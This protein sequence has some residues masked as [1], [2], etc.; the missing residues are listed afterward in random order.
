[1]Q[2]PRQQQGNNMFQ[3]PFAGMTNQYGG[4]NMGNMGGFG[5]NNQYFGGPMGRNF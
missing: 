4:P 5:G 1:M 3:Q 2:Q